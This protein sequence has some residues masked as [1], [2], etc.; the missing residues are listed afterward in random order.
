ME[1]HNRKSSSSRNNKDLIPEMSQTEK[2]S[3]KLLMMDRRQ[4]RKVS[5]IYE[6]NNIRAKP[7]VRL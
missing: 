7:R 2:L 5:H 3:M 4:D 1:E 6:L